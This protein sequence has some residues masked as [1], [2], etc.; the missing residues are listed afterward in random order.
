MNG[1]LVQTCDTLL[2]DLDGVVYAGSAAIPHAV[3]VL[4]A[5]RADGVQLAFV[6][7][8]ASRTPESIA[9]H[10]ADLGLPVDPAEVVTSAQAGARMLGERL[11][12]GAP[13]LV[14]GGEGL[15]RAVAE[16]GFA[17]VDSA[18]AQPAAVIQG[19]SPDVGWRQ[20]AQATFAIRAGARF[21]ATNTDRTIPTGEGIGPGNGLLVGVVAQATG[22]QPRVAGK[23]E[24]P[25]MAESVERT[26]AQRPLVVGDRLDTDI[27]GANNVDLPSLLVLTGVSTLA[28]LAVA[29]AAQ[30]PTFLGLDLRSLH[31]PPVALGDPL[32]SDGA[33]TSD[34]PAWLRWTRDSAVVITAIWRRLDH[35]R[36]AQGPDQALTDSESAALDQLHAARP[37][38]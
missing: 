22:V 19:F 26:H 4:S 29:P 2:L 35:A 24:V 13:V 25:L 30:R 18:A 9:D 16:R 21:F 14:V 17:V 33:Q 20:L 8:N 11:H 38:S 36:G 32:A 28:D 3:D 15:R 31:A 10:I 37:A 6:T 5:A 12:A 23:P 7:N 34:E 27:E 1:T